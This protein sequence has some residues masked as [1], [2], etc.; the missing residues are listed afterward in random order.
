VFKV[1]TAS[2]R[3]VSPQSRYKTCYVIDD[4]ANPAILSPLPVLEDILAEDRTAQ[5][6][7][8]ETAEIGFLDLL[9]SRYYGAGME[10]MWWVIA[11]VN[12]I[13]DPD[14]EMFVGQVL[15]IP[16]QTAVST[17]IARGGRPILGARSE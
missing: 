13:I 6:H 15:L 16:S 14:L 8:V 4:G 17:F 11:Y 10:S 5:L 1:Q 9:A 2:I 12:A 3:T 7:T